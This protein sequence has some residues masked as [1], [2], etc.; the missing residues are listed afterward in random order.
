M[1]KELVKYD[2]TSAAAKWAVKYR[3][4]IEYLPYAVQ[5]HIINN[6]DE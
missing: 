5:M 6:E 1:I 4:P 2:D 3:I